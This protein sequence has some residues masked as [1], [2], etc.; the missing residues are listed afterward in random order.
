MIFNLGNLDE[1]YDC[2]KVLNPDI[3]AD[4]FHKQT[5]KI[6]IHTIKVALQKR[7]RHEHIARL[8]NNHIIYPSLSSH[9]FR[10]IISNELDKIRC[11]M[12]EESALEVFFSSSVEKLLYDEGVFPVQGTRP[13]F[14]TI[15]HMIDANIMVIP[16]VILTNNLEV[17]YVHI[18][19]KRRKLIFQFYDKNQEVVFEHTEKITP[20]VS[21]I[22]V[23]KNDELQALTAVH[24]AGHVVASIFLLGQVPKQVFSLSSSPD[25]SGITITDTPERS[26]WNREMII[27]QSA[28]CL[29]GLVAEKIVF[30]EDKM[31]MG[32]S[33]DINMAT[34]IFSNMVRSSG[35]AGDMMYMG[36]ESTYFADGVFDPK[37]LANEKVKGF[38][39]MAE[40]LAEKTLVLYRP[41]LLE[42][43]RA[44]AVR[45]SL[46]RE[47][48]LK[49][50][51][52][53][54]N[55]SEK[56]ILALGGG[57]YRERLFKN[58]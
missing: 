29:A 31:S 24:E 13:L 34:K 9:A 6:N 49:I 56:E 32:A 27:G 26:V 54:C 33:S 14:S 57:G 22:R 55:L 47:N 12:Q 3:S 18:H 36:I 45:V 16:D 40:E 44:L 30:G 17:S 39:K 15:Q 7:F 20:T 21:D 28:V 11:K 46:S 53:C 19:Y 10:T 50:V 41:L 37:Y 25:A 4:T 42:L 5:S 38:L 2:A 51:Y 43:A 23:S 35:L 1:A 52:T 8:G 58:V 48:I